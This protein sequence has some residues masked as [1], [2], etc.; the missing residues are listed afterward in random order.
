MHECYQSR[1]T[2][3]LCDDDKYEKDG[4]CKECKDC[5]AGMYQKRECG[6]NLNRV[7]EPCPQVI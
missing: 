5:P 2:I 6:H 7:C 3:C 4:I 1:D